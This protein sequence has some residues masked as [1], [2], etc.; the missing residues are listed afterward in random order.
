MAIVSSYPQGTPTLNDTVIGTQYVENKEPVTKQFNINDIVDL[1]PVVYTQ[2][3]YKVFTALLTQSGG[4]DILYV[5]PGDTLT[6]GVTYLINDSF[7]GTDFTN[8]GAPNNNIGTYFVA[9]GTTPAN[10]GDVPEG[11]G[12]LSYNTGAPVATVL[13][14]TIGNV[15]FSYFEIGFYYCNS[16]G[17]FTSNKT[18]GQ[19][20]SRTAEDGSGFH[21]FTVLPNTVT[22]DLVD[23]YSTNPIEAIGTND[24]FYNT[25]IEIRVYN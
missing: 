18:F 25:P 6:I 8:V 17:L 9:T 11:A 7:L 10:W 5:Y 22:E 13:E 19:G 23:L 15:W 1:V 14:N 2:L 24:S 12:V 16:N 21:V 20:T 3:P 4:D